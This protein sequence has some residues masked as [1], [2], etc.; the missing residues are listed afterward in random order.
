MPEEWIQ[1]QPWSW[2]RQSVVSFL[3]QS[4]SARLPLVRPVATRFP[5]RNWQ[6]TWL[7]LVSYSAS[8]FDIA[9]RL[10]ILLLTRGL[11]GAH[12]QRGCGLVTVNLNICYILSSFAQSYG[13][14]SSALSRTARWKSFALTR[15]RRLN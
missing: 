11:D 3:P 13:W 8:R 4:H 5:C 7:H 2:I 15:L 9:A 14:S 12:A 6:A 10:V 1:Y